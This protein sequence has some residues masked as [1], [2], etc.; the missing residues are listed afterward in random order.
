MQCAVCSVLCTVFSLKCAVCY[1]TLAIP[2]ASGLLI[3][4]SDPS[5]LPTQWSEPR[6]PRLLQQEQ[7]REQEHEQ[8]QEQ[9]QEQELEQIPICGKNLLVGLHHMRVV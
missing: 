8:E 7:E 9:E 1:L 6:G 2:G 4:S 5:L 3:P